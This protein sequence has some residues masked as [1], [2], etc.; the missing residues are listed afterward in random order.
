MEIANKIDHTALGPDT[1]EEQVINLCKE[2]K[3]HGFFSVC[4]NPSW[5][6]TASQRL[7]GSSVKICTVVGFPLGAT[8]TEVKAFETKDAI[9]KG[10]HEIDMVMNIAKLKE[11]DDSYVEKDI[12]AVVKAANDQALVKVIIETCLLT[13]EEKKTAC[14]LAVKAGADYVKTSTGFS[15]GGATI[16]DIKLMRQTVGPNIGVKASGG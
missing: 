11:G 7:E 10:A 1:T 5:V 13:D 9:E 14:E 8:S 6:K 4:I 15:T 2:A 12:Q 3:E 16:E